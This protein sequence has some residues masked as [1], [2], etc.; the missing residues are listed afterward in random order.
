MT[1]AAPK[2][3]PGRAPGQAAH[4][5]TA[6]SKATQPTDKSETAASPA[7]S[8]PSVL[9][10]VGVSGSGKST[11][12]AL[13]AQRLG[14]TFEDA[15]WFHP[16]A[17]V[18]KLSSGTPLTDKDR[19]PWLEAIAGWIDA[20]RAAERHGVIACSALKRSYRA[21]LLGAHGD[22]VRIVYLDGSRELIGA[23]LAL[24]HGHFMPPGL[25]E[26]QFSTLE[27][28]VGEEHGISVSIDAHPREV[29]DAIVAAIET[30]LGATIPV[31][32]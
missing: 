17:N 27:V 9:V 15:D 19:W 13:L 20:T 10:V 23:R 30:D 16:A 32:P 26:S 7:K 1:A 11:I 12:A 21:V 14:W 18:E 4:R 6:A 5:R 28:P 24:R 2:P 22:A 29:V 25:L 8:P 3:V 31:G